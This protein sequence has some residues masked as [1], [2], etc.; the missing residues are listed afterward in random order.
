MNNLNKLVLEGITLKSGEVIYNDCEID[1]N[2]SF[3]EQEWSFKEDILQIKFDTAESA[4]TVDVG[5]IPEFNK[6][7]KFVVQVIKNY[8]W[9]KPISS[10]KVKTF[11]ALK[12][13]LQEAIDIA[14]ESINGKIH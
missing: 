9:E 12:K 7:G 3:E 1:P 8:E 13:C 11:A 6:N 2:L 4:Y 14:D 10:K 5:W